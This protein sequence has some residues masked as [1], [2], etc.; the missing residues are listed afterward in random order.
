MKKLNTTILLL[1]L[2]CMFA[3]DRQT[4]RP[5]PSMLEAEKV[6]EDYPDSARSLLA[7]MKRNIGIENMP[8]QMYYDMLC[9]KAD[10]KCYIIHTSDSTMQKVVKYYEH[11]GKKEQLMEAYYLMGRVYRDMGF[12]AQALECYHKALDMQMQDNTNTY[13]IRYYSNSQIGHIYMYQNLYRDAQY[14]FE[15]AYSETLHAKYTMGIIYSLRDLG[16]CYHSQGN[17]HKGIWYYEKSLSL[18]KKEN[19]ISVYKDIV[20]ELALL[21]IQNKEY[22]KAKKCLEMGEALL[23]SKSQNQILSVYYNIHGDLYNTMEKKDSAAYYYKKSLKY[24]YPYANQAAA[25]SLY[26]IYD[27]KKDYAQASNYAFE[28]AL[29]TDSINTMNLEKNHS[30]IQTLNHKLQV[31]QENS[32][33]K[34]KEINLKV[35]ILLLVI[36]TLVIIVVG[37]A[38]FRGKSRKAKQR[39]EGLQKAL[40]EQQRQSEAVKAENERHIAELNRQLDVSE[41]QKEDEVQKRLLELKKKMLLESNSRIDDEQEERMLLV[42]EFQ[43]SV[44]YQSFHHHVTGNLKDEDFAELRKA[45]DKAYKGFSQRLTE[46]YPSIKEKEMR[47]CLLIKAG[48][49]PTEIGNIMHYSSA[50]ATMMRRRLYT[51]IFDKVGSPDDFDSFIR[52]L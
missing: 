29:C 42:Q 47:T 4:I 34:L 17:L 31:E 37:M 11:H 28:L 10:D 32:R 14:Y 23:N 36:C 39:Q 22:A 24:N 21:Y 12:M 52:R 30:L 41:L 33:L 50:N 25:Q 7:G 15:R 46:L 13:T 1:C 51:K 49:S 3:C 5:I 38:Y 40:D 19:Q 8:T 45:L 44:I 2:F 16:R 6:M 18:V 9:V 20:G 27:E 26:L 48:M 43:G 35:M